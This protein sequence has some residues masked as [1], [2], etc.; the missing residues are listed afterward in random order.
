MAKLLRSEPKP[1]S[2]AGDLQMRKFQ[3]L[4]YNDLAH[5]RGTSSQDGG[6]V[7]NALAGNAAEPEFYFSLRLIAYQSSGKEDQSETGL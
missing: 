7:G 1:E 3:A 2:R 5:G 4:V 6:T